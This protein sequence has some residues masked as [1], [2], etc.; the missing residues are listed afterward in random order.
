MGFL[1]R[2]FGPNTIDEKF[3]SSPMRDNW[4]QSISCWPSSFSLITTA[5]EDGSTN[6]GPYQLTVP[7]E[8]IKE[9]G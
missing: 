9:R 3:A 7:F 8:L 2:L 1:G 6:I 5:S 4:Y